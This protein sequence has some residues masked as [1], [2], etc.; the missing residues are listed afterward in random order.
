MEEVKKP[1]KIS[2]SEWEIMR[3]VWTLGDTTAQEIT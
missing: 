1:I 3:V 2:D